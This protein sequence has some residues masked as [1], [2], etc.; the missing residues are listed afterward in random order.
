[1]RFLEE[2]VEHFQRDSIGP[3]HALQAQHDIA[4]MALLGFVRRGLQVLL[5]IGRRAEEELALEIIDEHVSARRIGGDPRPHDLLR[6]DDELLHLEVAPCAACTRPTE[7]ADPI[8]IANSTSMNTAARAVVSSRIA[9]ARE[10]V[11]V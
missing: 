10:A 3:S 11:A 6:R 9:S 8:R 7:T 4:D 1:M 2:H 5:E